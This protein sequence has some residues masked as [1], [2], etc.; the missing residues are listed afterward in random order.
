MMLFWQNR[1]VEAIE[2]KGGCCKICGYNKC[3]ESMDFHH[4][5][6][7]D[8]EYDWNK[9]RLTSWEK[10]TKELD[11]CD[12]LCKNCHA[13]EHVRLRINNSKRKKKDV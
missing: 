1:K 3:K 5:N 4:R 9:L 11:K 10:I 7:E 12:L 2:Y 6:P 13:E 8:K